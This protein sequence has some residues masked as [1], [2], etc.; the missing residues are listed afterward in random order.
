MR[1]YPKILRTKLRPNP[2]NPRFIT[3]EKKELLKKSFTELTALQKLRP[4]IVDRNMMALGGNQRLDAAAAIGQKYVYY[5]VFTEQMADEMNAEAEEQ[6]RET[7]TYDYYCKQIIITDNS[8]FG[9]YSF[10]MIDEQW[11]EYPVEDW[12]LDYV[13]WDIDNI[14]LDDDNVNEDDFNENIK[15]KVDVKQGDVIQIGKHKLICGDSTEPEVYRKL[16]GNDNIKCAIVD[17][18]Y[19]IDFKYNKHKDI[20]GDVYESFCDK[21]FKNIKDETSTIIIFTGWNYN[22]F[23]FNLEPYEVFYW[24]VKD[25]HTGGKNSHFRRTEPIMMWGKLDHKF[26]TDFII[27]ESVRYKDEHA[28]QH[29]CPK[30]VSTIDLFMKAASAKK[31]IVLDV[32]LGSGTTMVTAQQTSRICYGIETDERYCELTILRMLKLNNRL[33]VSI[34]GKDRTKHYL[35][36]LFLS[37]E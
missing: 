19:G 34:N 8:G 30:N 9:E 5:D 17:P 33:D 21:W 36:K 7:R 11:G 37:I 6:G 27:Q 4:I 18:P 10:K 2:D 32:F 16:I 23:W 14:D 3:D 15:I 29:T 25:R 13:N 22:K 26:G 28:S 24:I 20:E 12:G 31:D 35:D 1:S